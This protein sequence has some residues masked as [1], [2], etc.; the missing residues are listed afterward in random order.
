MAARTVSKHNEQGRP[1]SAGK[2]LVHI[3]SLRKAVPFVPSASTYLSWLCACAAV[4]ELDGGDGALPASRMLQLLRA[5]LDGAARSL[6]PPS[7]QLQG[8]AP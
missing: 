1:L 6:N 3:A 2:A 8:A 5:L 4:L 7:L